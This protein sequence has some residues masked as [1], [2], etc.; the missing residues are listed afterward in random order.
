MKKLL[1]P[2]MMLALAGCAIH[3]NVPIATPLPVAPTSS[4]DKTVYA[5]PNEQAYVEAVQSDGLVPKYGPA[6]RA[7]E[8]AHTICGAF[9]QGATGGMI[10]Q[11]GSQG[12]RI[13]YVAMEL[14]VYE[15]TN[16]LC[17]VFRGH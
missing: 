14:F 12:S 8:L 11:T 5:D 10:A 16:N 3:P 7:I 17:P 1:I 13:P 2:M 9:A 6:S 15:A 4:P